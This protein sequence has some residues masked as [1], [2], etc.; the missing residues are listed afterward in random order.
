[1]GIPVTTGDT[2]AS[3]ICK[4]SSSMIS[5]VI[6]VTTGV[7]GLFAVLS[8]WTSGV[9]SSAYQ[10]GSFRSCSACLLTNSPPASISKF[11]APNCLV[12]APSI[13]R[14]SDTKLHNSTESL[15]L[16]YRRGAMTLVLR[17]ILFL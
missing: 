1:M 7:P 16:K 8:A 4:L 10:I 17:P 3:S 12:M 6:S 5:L 9:H 15:T 14:P 13:H 11:T 2:V